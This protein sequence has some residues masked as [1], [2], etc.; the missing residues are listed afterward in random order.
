[1]RV[2]ARALLAVAAILLLASPLGVQAGNPGVPIQP[3]MKAAVVPLEVSMKVD[4]VYGFSSRDQTFTV[5][6]TLHVAAPTAIMRKTE[7][8]ELALQLASLGGYAVLLAWTAS[9]P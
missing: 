6:G 9:Q 2:A 7:R 4:N 3:Q 8:L 1:M 5:E